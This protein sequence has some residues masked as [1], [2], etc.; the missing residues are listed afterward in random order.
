[1]PDRGCVHCGRP[2]DWHAPETLAC[3]GSSRTVFA[4]MDLPASKTCG[5][6]IYFRRTCE[7]LISCEP[8]RVTCD[9]WPIRFVPITPMEVRADV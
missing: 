9:W 5:D 4:T 7:W 1:M 2:K 3:P 8:D 6:C